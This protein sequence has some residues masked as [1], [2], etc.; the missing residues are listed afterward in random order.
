[1]IGRGNQKPSEE[2]RA[3]PQSAYAQSLVRDDRFVDIEWDERCQNEISGAIPLP[4]NVNL[5]FALGVRADAGGD[6]EGGDAERERRAAAPLAFGGERGPRITADEQFALEMAV[7]DKNYDA[8]M[9]LLEATPELF[10]HVEQ[11]GDVLR[12]TLVDHPPFRT[13]YPAFH[14]KLVAMQA[15]RRTTMAELGISD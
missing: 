6:A 7:R 10:K 15:Q 8:A 4:W 2:V 9:A 5:F 1:M 11:T 13:A 14:A 12:W 3:H